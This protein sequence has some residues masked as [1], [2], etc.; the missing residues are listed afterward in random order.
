MAWSTPGP[1]ERFTCEVLHATAPAAALLHMVALEWSHSRKGRHI[2]AWEG[3]AALCNA[4]S[5]CARFG[6]PRLLLEQL[7]EAVRGTAS[8]PEVVTIGDEPSRGLVEWLHQ[9]HGWQVTQ[10]TLSRESLTIAIPA[11]ANRTA[12]TLLLLLGSTDRWAWPAMIEA[13]RPW[14]I[15]V[16]ETSAVPS[17]DGRGSWAQDR[18]ALQ[19]QARLLGYESHQMP[20]ELGAGSTDA[21]TARRRT[22]RRS[23]KER[24]KRHRPTTS[25]PEPPRGLTTMW[26]VA[27]DCEMPLWDLRREVGRATAAEV[28]AAAAAARLGIRHSEWF[29]CSTLE[30]LR[31]SRALSTR[32]HTRMSAYTCMHA[33]ACTRMHIAART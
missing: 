9:A 7:N 13:V 25:A 16:N 17:A 30:V 15:I 22:R 33:H 11:M 12:A 19:D 28:A 3:H 32:P 1:A 6:Q 5:P 24:A 27:Q 4:W 26:R 29:A 18:A 10:V 20:Y 8:P 31:S 2:P 21:D 14:V 23:R